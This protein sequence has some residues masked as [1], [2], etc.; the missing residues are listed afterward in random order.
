VL[1]V[2]SIAFLDLIVL[3][4]F[5]FAIVLSLLVSWIIKFSSS[6]PMYKLYIYIYIYIYTRWFKY[7]RDWLRLVYTQISPGHIWT[8]LYIYIYIYIYTYIYIHTYVHTYIHTHIYVEDK[9]PN[10]CHNLL[11]FISLLLCSTCFGH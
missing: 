8:T 9:R 10:W 11:S 1:H 7:D 5:E 3:L 2:Q 6:L 4:I